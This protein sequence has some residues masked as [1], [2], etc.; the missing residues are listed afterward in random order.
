VSYQALLRVIGAWLDDDCA[1]GATLVETPDGWAVRYGFERH[2]P[3]ALLKQFS[4]AALKDLNAIRK[5]RRNSDPNTRSRAGRHEDLFRTIGFELDAVGASN[6]L[7]DHIGPDLLVT[8]EAQHPA[9]GFSWRKEMLVVG[10]DVGDG[11]LQQARQ[12]RAPVPDHSW[13][14]WLR[15]PAGGHV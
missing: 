1:T 6:V 9:Q 3:P 14:S 2:S 8:F 10:S 7:I 4:D 15:A 5:Q 13:L 11:L 12:R